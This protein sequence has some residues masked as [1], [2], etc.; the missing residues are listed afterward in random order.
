[1]D[2]A[3]RETEE[4]DNPNCVV[5]GEKRDPPPD[6]WRDIPQT[7]P[8]HPWVGGPPYENVETGESRD[9]PPDGW[10][11]I[12]AVMAQMNPNH[13]CVGGSS[14][15][16]NHPWNRV[17]NADGAWSYVNGESGERQS[18]H[19]HGWQHIDARSGFFGP[20]AVKLPSRFPM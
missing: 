11:D 19:P 6:G 16:R 1:M 5:T 20:G 3:K 13:P 15:N 7:N 2:D 17:Q 8:N 10:L 9:A 4:R 18:Y 12:L 14:D